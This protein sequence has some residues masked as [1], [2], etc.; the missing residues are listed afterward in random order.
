[1]TYLFISNTAIC[2]I[3]LVTIEKVLLL[4]QGDLQSHDTLFQSRSW[5]AASFVICTN[6]TTFIIWC[7]NYSRITNFIVITFWDILCCP[8][9]NNILT[10]ILEKN[11]FLTHLILHFFCILTFTLGTWINNTMESLQLF[12]SFSF[13]LINKF[14]FCKSK[15]FYCLMN[16]KKLWFLLFYF[17]EHNKHA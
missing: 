15:I 5:K 13:S 8:I 6:F 9:N 3:S 2:I 11:K 12:S 1:M 7:G 10:I 17:K 16:W 4:L 14:L